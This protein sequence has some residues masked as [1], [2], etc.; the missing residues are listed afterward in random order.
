MDVNKKSAAYLD[1]L[2]GL[3][4]KEIALKHEIPLSTVKSWAHR[5]WGNRNTQKSTPDAV[6][7]E[8]PPQSRGAPMGNQNAKGHGAPPRNRNNYKHGIYETIWWET[9]SAEEWLMIAKMP[10]IE[11]VELLNQIR[12]LSIRERRVLQYIHQIATLH[13]EDYRKAE[14][15]RTSQIDGN[16]VKGQVQNHREKT[17]NYPAPFEVQIKAEAELT[18]IQEQK[19][20]CIELLHNIRLAQRR[21]EEGEADDALVD[22]WIHAVLT[23]WGP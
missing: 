20:R 3:K 17:V 18:R 12:L 1:W 9:L 5:S 4:Y 22:D 6:Q 2:D 11:E 8:A 7:S 14:T 23:Q 21:Y 15:K 19:T 13:H 10:C 16:I